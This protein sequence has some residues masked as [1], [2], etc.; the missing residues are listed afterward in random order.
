MPSDNSPTPLNR[1][2]FHRPLGPS[3]IDNQQTIARTLSAAANKKNSVERPVDRR[4]YGKASA[5]ANQP[6]APIMFIAPETAPVCSRPRSEQT[7]QLELTVKSSPNTTTP[8]QKMNQPAE[9]V[10]LAN[11]WPAD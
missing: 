4:A 6:N 7:V 1:K 11:A 5:Q 10:K 3:P 8:N 2:P 9:V